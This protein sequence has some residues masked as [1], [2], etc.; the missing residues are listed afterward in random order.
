M[1]QSSV[2]SLYLLSTS[3]L[4]NLQEVKNYDTILIITVLIITT[5]ISNCG[6]GINIFTQATCNCITKLLMLLK[7]YKN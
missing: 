2:N 4:F 7:H 3:L 1:M 6:L 5:H